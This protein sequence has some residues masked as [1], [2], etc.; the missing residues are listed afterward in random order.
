[1]GSVPTQ[2]FNMFTHKLV[3]MKWVQVQKSWYHWPARPSASSG[4]TTRTFEGSLRASLKWFWAH[5]SGIRSHL[6]AWYRVRAGIRNGGMVGKAFP[7]ICSHVPVFLPSAQTHHSGSKQIKWSHVC[8][9][10]CLQV[11]EHLTD[12]LVEEQKL[13]DNFQESNSTAQKVRHKQ[14][15]LEWVCSGRMIVFH[16]SSF[17]RWPSSLEMSVLIW[18]CVYCCQKKGTGVRSVC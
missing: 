12:I 4:Q 1:M 18:C 7:W 6:S 15:N 5:W 16:F 3:W 9:S 8:L 13:R 11:N 17:K 14:D 10:V 2:R